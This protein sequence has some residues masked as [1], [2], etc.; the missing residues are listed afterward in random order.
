[1]VIFF[2]AEEETKTEQD[3]Q[4]PIT[5]PELQ[6]NES[7]IPTTSDETDTQNV[8][9][10]A[11]QPSSPVNS[12]TSKSNLKDTVPT[13]GNRGRGRPP[14]S[15]SGASAAGSKKSDTETVK[16]PPVRF[17]TSTDPVTVPG[18]HP[19]VRIYE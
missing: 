4:I 11:T 5:L 13:T 9:F 18:T 1:M 8:A 14:L 12:Q 10:S 3:N 6:N 19:L 7:G 2:S 16:Q 15:Q 17:S